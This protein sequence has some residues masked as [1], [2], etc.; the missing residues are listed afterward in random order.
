MASPKLLG[1]A[2]VLVLGLTAAGFYFLREG[3]TPGPIPEPPKKAKQA[4]EP[5]LFEDVTASSGV[6][7]SYRNGEDVVDA[8]GQP[9]VDE[10][11][12][13]LRHLSILE[14]LGG[15]AALLDFDGDGRLDIFLTG[16]GHYAGPPDYHRI[17]GH[18]CRLYRNLGG[19]K[20]VDATAAAGLDKLTE[21][22][23]WFYSHGTAV[24]DVDRDGWADL[25]VAG[26]GGVALLRNVA[27][28]GGKGR[29][30]E[31]VT[32][33]AGLDRGL[34]WASSAGFGDLDGDGY[35]D[36]YVCQ[37]VD[38]SFKKH[39]S[40]TY[41]GK[42]PDV[43]PPRNFDG[44]QHHVYRND[45]KGG[46]VDVTRE[47]GLLPGGPQA[48]KGLG[49]LLVDLDGDG[50]TDVYVANDTVDNFLYL[51]RSVPG[52]I[53]LEEKALLSGAAR[54]DRGTANGSMG[55]DAGDPERTGRPSLWVTNYQNELHSLYANECRPGKMFFHFRTAGA[56]IAAI[57]QNYVGWGT[58]FVDVD[59]DGWED[60]FVSNGHAIRYPGGK[61]ADRPQRPVLLL[62]KEGKFRE[63]GAR[64][65]TYGARVH[66][67]R[68][69]ALGDLEDD[70]RIDI[71]LTHMNEPA[72]ILRGIG[73]EKN[74]WLGIRLVGK[75]HACV[76]GVKATLDIGEAKPLTRFA[77]GG[78]SFASSG[79][80]RLHFG[81]GAA[82]PGTLTV[83][84]PNGTTQEFKNLAPDR[85]YRIEQGKNEAQVEP[86]AK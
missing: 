40:C 81:L 58:G 2:L 8:Q 59:L 54:D 12:R 64:L 33:R 79:D 19:M 24:A 65:G 22:K 50:K 37:Y 38:W 15:G 13:P 71:V 14:S 6:A 18:P 45:G 86:E 85:Y 16:G 82:L 57:G 53:R 11:G 78:G 31:D 61:E 26:W 39:P 51:N 36:L 17:V 63:V 60:L 34:D 49:V 73:G 83:A 80:R 72:A 41:D 7:F 25:L 48:S 4:I 55:I 42:T 46:F 3:E 23:D 35:P 43:C 66:L 74:H 52:T 67:G 29:R 9:V 70:G 10:K 28:E 44:L 20:F 76:V 62:N 77:K 75:G 84:W 69:A 21:G 30:F 32:A 5:P 47:A 68:G 27:A 1:A 56:G